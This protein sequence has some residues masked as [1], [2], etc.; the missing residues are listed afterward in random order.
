MTAIKYICC[1]ATCMAKWLLVIFTQILCYNNI[2]L[3]CVGIIQLVFH[4]S[5]SW[6][7][8]C[9]KAIQSCAMLLVTGLLFL[10]SG[11]WWKKAP[12][13]SHTH[14]HTSSVYTKIQLAKLIAFEISLSFTDRSMNYFFPCFGVCV[15]RFFRIAVSDQSTRGVINQ[16]T[17]ISYITRNDK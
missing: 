2:C 5:C 14:T 6:F 3:V 10:H 17:F 7:N 13:F 16:I 9:N 4:G 8:N 11:K 1:I 12:F 15:V